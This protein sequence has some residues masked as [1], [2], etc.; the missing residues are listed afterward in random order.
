MRGGYIVL[1]ALARAESPA[2]TAFW[3]ES[4][5]P[6]AVIHPRKLESLSCR[7]AELQ[8]SEMVLPFSAFHPGTPARS[9]IKSSRSHTCLFEADGLERRPR[10]ALRWSL[11]D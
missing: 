2:M 5:E 11:A 7:L 9:S 10:K 1:M 3:N 6:P 8:G 4:Y